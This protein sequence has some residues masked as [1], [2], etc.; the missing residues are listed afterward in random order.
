MKQV[1][2]QISVK[3][4]YLT[5]KFESQSYSLLAQKNYCSIRVLCQYVRTGHSTVTDIVPQ[6]SWGWDHNVITYCTPA[7]LGEVYSQ[8][9][10]DHCHTQAE[11]GEVFHS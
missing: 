9:S 5:W 1:S 6:L 10:W 11:L 2:I 4:E 8:L 3:I 7:E